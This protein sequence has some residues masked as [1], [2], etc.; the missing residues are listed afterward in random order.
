MG[1]APHDVGIAAIANLR[2]TPR[3]LARPDPE[4]WIGGFTCAQ[5][6]RPHENLAGEQAETY[7]G[8]KHTGGKSRGWATGTSYV[9]LDRGH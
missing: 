3:N 7:A 6:V 5:D 1:R 8:R 4:L 2:T 9:H